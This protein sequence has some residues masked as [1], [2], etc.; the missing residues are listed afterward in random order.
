[1]FALASLTFN[2]SQMPQWKMDTLVKTAR[3]W[4]QKG[5]NRT[6]RLAKY[7][8]IYLGL[9]RFNNTLG[10]DFILALFYLNSLSLLECFNIKRILISHVSIHSF[11]S[12]SMIAHAEVK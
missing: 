10:I 7:I 12:L 3:L 5:N 11:L 1:M 8:K 6:N 4:K 9:N 2:K